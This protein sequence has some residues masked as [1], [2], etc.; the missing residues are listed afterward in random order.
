[1]TVLVLDLDGVVVRG[2]P[3]G[4]RWD[5]NL[6]RDLG[7]DARMVQEKFFRP[8]FQKIAIG[9]ADLFETLDRVWPEL[10]S[11]VTAREFVDYW[12]AMDSL[13]DDA[14]L[15][16]VDGWRRGGRRAYLATI[17][18]HYRARHIWNILGA[19]FDG[20]F[21][22]ADLNARK[23]ERVFYERVMAKLSDNV[24]SDV[25]FLDDNLANV[26]GA[27]AFGWLAHH[28][29]DAADL[30]KAISALPSR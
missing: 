1:M 25:L 12:F 9:E 27:V 11:R 21:Y 3:D 8:H 22:S 26:E 24:P 7:I 14:V 23:P 5:K 15:A 19:H 4:G 28:F 17:Q 18:E 10:G 2:H 13:L 16:Q 29:T 20:I 30:R 6:E